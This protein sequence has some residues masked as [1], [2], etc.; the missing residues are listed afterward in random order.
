M[1]EEVCK[2]GLEE[3]TKSPNSDSNNCSPSSKKSKV[4]G[5][6][7]EERNEK[8]LPELV[9]ELLG[10][11]ALNKL[12]P[13]STSSGSEDTKP[14]DEVKAEGVDETDFDVYPMT[15]Y[16][17]GPA[18]IINNELFAKMPSRP[19]TEKDGKAL[20][21]LF[22]HFGFVTSTYNDLTA[23][24]M[25]STLQSF[26]RRNHMF[27]Q[28]LIV[29]I[30]SHGEEGGLLHGS[31][32][33]LI[34]IKELADL[35]TGHKCSSLVGKPK[36][37]FIQ[38]CR[39]KMFDTP[40]TGYEGIDGYRPM[41]VTEDNVDGLKKAL[42]P[43]QSDFLLSF[44]TV[45]GY[46]SWRNSVYG[47]WYVKAMVEVFMEFAAKEHIMDMLTEVSR[48]VAENQSQSGFKQIP[49]IVSHLRKQLYFNPGKIT[50]RFLKN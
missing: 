25:K 13:L 24:E 32:D 37:F 12:Y 33:V 35:F 21:H 39:G 23:D 31:D 4:D 45:E 50:K 42:L 19:G 49:A 26:A 40:A 1:S 11:E 29:A 10:T 41:V 28:C 16:P 14:Q 22:T 5:P 36:L 17:R 18:V 30:L 8:P 34:D 44:S 2:R 7:E 48:K 38:A 9:K 6:I 3:G 27:A 46:V 43:E 20:E 47:S 15:A